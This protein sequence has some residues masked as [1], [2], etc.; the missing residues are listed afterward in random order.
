MKKLALRLLL[1]IGMFIALLLLMDLEAVGIATHERLG[2]AMGV[3]CLVHILQHLPWIRAVV[4]QS[5][6]GLMTRKMG[7][8]RALNLSLGGGCFLSAI[9]GIMISRTLPLP[10]PMADAATVTLLHHSFAYLTLILTALHLGIHARACLVYALVRVPCKLHALTKHI[11]RVAAVLMLLAGMRAFMILNYHQVIASPVTGSSPLVEPLPNARIQQEYTNNTYQDMVDPGDENDYLAGMV[12]T[13]CSRRC[14]LLQPECQIGL[15]QRREAESTHIENIRYY[16]N[17]TS[18]VSD[19]KNELAGL[20][21]TG[22]SRMCSL[23]QPECLI[24]VRQLREAQEG[25]AADSSGPRELDP[26]TKGWMDN[27]SVDAKVFQFPLVLGMFAVG[28]HYFS[29]WQD[30]KDL[31]RRRTND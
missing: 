29:G 9:T 28:S 18:S 12:C 23:L 19:N 30:K 1:D 15:R 4:K 3:V 17:T 10:T 31:G 16:Q 5:R 26:S 22:C 21:C 25:F 11:S 7:Y 14:L 6:R 13:G 8:M 2:V 20:I 27:F 24:G